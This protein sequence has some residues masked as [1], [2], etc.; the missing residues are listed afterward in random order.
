MRRA[1][2]EWLPSSPPGPKPRSGIA[3]E[4]GRRAWRSEREEGE[5]KNWL[6]SIRLMG[7]GGF[8]K[9]T[10]GEK[11]SINFEGRYMCC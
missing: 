1:E 3:G 4:G 5:N 10:R 11:T 9:S 6:M 2:S 7:K 8:D